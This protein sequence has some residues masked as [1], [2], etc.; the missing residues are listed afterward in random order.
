MHH[1]FPL[2]AYRVS[3]SAV[4]AVL[5]VLALLRP[6]PA[7]PAGVVGSGKPESCTEAA[8]DAAL[9]GG[10][11]V[12]FN[13]GGAATITVT[14][15]KTISADTTI[16][17]GSLITISGG[18][19]VGVFLAGNGVRFTVQ[20][21]TIANGNAASGAGISNDG[22]LTVTNSTFTDNSAGDGGGIA[23]TGGTLTVTNSTFSG[24]S[25]TSYCNPPCAGSE[26]RVGGGIGGGIANTGTL[27]VT[28][29]SF[30]GNS[31][32]DG[33]AIRN[34]GTLT[35]T[36]SS[37]S[38]NS[39]LYGG[40]IGNYGT[41]TVINST[42]SSNSTSAGFGGGIF[43]DAG[44]LTVTNSTFSSNSA[45]YYGGGIGN[46]GYPGS[47]GRLTVTN[48]TFSGNSADTRGGGIWSYSTLTV[49]NSTFSS[50]SAPDGG[51]IWSYGT[52][53]VTN[54]SF[55]GNSGN[56]IQSG[57]GIQQSE[58]GTLTVTST[59]IANSMNGGDC[60]NTGALTDGGHN[61]I[62]DT[63]SS[64]GLTHGVNGNIVG[65]A[66]MLDPDGLQDH[67]GPTQ[68]IALLPSSPAINAGDADV[69]ATAPVN[70]VDQRGYVRP[71]TGHA[72]C[73]IGAYEA[74]AFSPEACV[75]D[76]NGTGSATIDELI[77]LVNI[78]LGTAQPSA[79]PHGI[80]S[81]TDV[82]V[83]VIIQA[84]NNALI[85]C[86][87]VCGNGSVEPGEDCD[88]GGT[89]I[90]GSNAGMACT[91]E[92]E[93]LGTGVCMGGA[94]VGVACEP[95]DANACP[96]STC[97]KC[98]PS[99]GDGCAANCTTETDVPFYLVPGR[100]DAGIAAGTS[101]DFIHADPYMIP[102]P[103]SGTQMLTVGKERDGQIPV[104]IK[105]ATVHFA[106]IPLLTLA[107]E[108]VRAV[109][110]KTCGGTWLEAD[111][112]TPS[113]DCTPGYTDGDSVCA[114][115]HPCAFVHGAG[116]AAAGVIGCAGLDAINANVERDGTG[117][118]PDFPCISDADCTITGLCIYTSEQGGMCSPPPR[119]PRITL[120]G[121][122]GAGSALL[123]SSRAI[124]GSH[125]VDLCTGTGPD[126]G[127]DGQFCTDDDPQDTRG[128]VI[129]TP[130][131]TGTA[132]GV[133]LNANGYADTT[134][135]PFTV[136][137]SPVSCG[138][139]LGPQS[140]AMPATL[141]SALTAPGFPIGPRIST[142]H[143]VVT[144]LLAAGPPIP[145]PSITN[146]SQPTPTLTLTPT[147]THTPSRTLT[148][149]A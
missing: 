33:G 16:D 67:G 45:G 31:A 63:E 146:T 133:F 70:G 57:Y 139:L 30:S 61:L 1:R 130:Q 109:A 141:A 71:G 117:A 17:G 104:V 41:L 95:S 84:V 118:G 65:G 83:A 49:T 53:T 73:S 4:F 64:C 148:G 105:A 43:N 108:C 48:S 145:T 128:T 51:G 102:M 7:L 134:V 42:F 93:C 77:T 85:G 122:G 140:V 78:A 6:I 96:G 100:V 121:T 13:C 98:V 24:N 39:A 11:M 74:D 137:G 8:L 28:N 120:T 21:L 47:S 76:C 81:G 143:A 119:P 92:A 101:G 32:L 131:T 136:A 91:A 66:P 60:V 26:R 103:L 127:A 59:I 75:G 35:V 46:S 12:T 56:A 27:T 112:V 5:L 138:A 38:S 62:E 54:S 52:L 72:N 111:G 129:T 113:L 9:A 86:G 115:K 94:H 40:G 2:A 15:T 3:L 110:A 50:N 114:G 10:G 80:P 29:S 89:C 142:G 25:A 34:H 125:A 79:C 99:G 82:T 149:A 58:G 116:N 135:G 23:N 18:N 147:P 132:S 37:F 123:L 106:G 44:T 126:Y 107:C 19:S 87:F 88:D 14:S 69:C 36:N 22:T 90:G 144:E 20:N 68:T 55:S 124:G 97:R